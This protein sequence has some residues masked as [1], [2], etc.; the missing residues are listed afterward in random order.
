MITRGAGAAT[1]SAYKCNVASI[2]GERVT[3][4][5]V[6]LEGMK[7]KNTDGD[8]IGISGTTSASLMKWNNSIHGVC[9]KVEMACIEAPTGGT[10]DIVLKASA[11]AG[12]TYNDA[13]GAPSILAAGGDWVIGK[14]LGTDGAN[15]TQTQIND[16]DAI[17]LTSGDGNTDGVY[18]AGKYIIKF[19]GVKS[20]FS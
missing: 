9:Y 12:F 13:C 3:T 10:E 17:Y 19:Y 20:D 18:T 5:L 1:G 11:S 15:G 6:D 16:G 14:R 7:S 4:L 8:V 2:N